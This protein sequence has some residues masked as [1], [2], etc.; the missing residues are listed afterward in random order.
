[1]MLFVKTIAIISQRKCESYGKSS[2]H[3]KN[4]NIYLFKIQLSIVILTYTRNFTSNKHQLHHTSRAL[5]ERNRRLAVS[6]VC[7]IKNPS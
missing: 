1:M 7:T 4:R 6:I 2:P 3:L 5:A